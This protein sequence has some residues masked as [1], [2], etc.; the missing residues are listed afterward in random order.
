MYALVFEDLGNQDSLE[1]EIIQWN[2]TCIMPLASKASTGIHIYVPMVIIETWLCTLKGG[3]LH[4]SL[5]D[6]ECILVWSISF[7]LN[8]TYSWYSII[9]LN[10]KTCTYK[11]YN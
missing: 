10:S 5:D 3:T 1:N 6:D 11:Q 8:N 7:L 4:V 2:I 9:L